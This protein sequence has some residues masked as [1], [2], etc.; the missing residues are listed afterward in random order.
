[1]ADY[2]YLYCRNHG[3]LSHVIVHESAHA[4]FASKYGIEFHDVTVLPPAEWATQGEN[5]RAG[6][7]R[8]IQNGTLWVPEMPELAMDLAMVGSV[9]EE[10]AYRHHLDASY[11]G[12]VWFWAAGMGMQATEEN[13]RKIA[14]ELRPLVEESRK[15][16]WAG[17]LQAVLADTEK[18]ARALIAKVETTDGKYYQVLN[19]PLVLTAEEVARIIQPST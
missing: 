19:E 14:K 15:R 11:V 6:G 10:K 1:M 17:T 18:I 8:P 13:V 5:R 9:A 7:V 12:D 4:A 3:W 2:D 16:L